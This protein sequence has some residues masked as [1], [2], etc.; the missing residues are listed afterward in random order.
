MSKYNYKEHVKEDLKRWLK[1]NNI[2]Q[3][4]TDEKWT[5]DEFRDWI[6]DEVWDDDDVTGNGTFFY[7]TEEKCSEYLSGN[8]N[9]LYNAIEE[10]HPDDNVNII[11]EEYENKSIARFF[12]CVIR[13]YFLGE[14]IE[15]IIEELKDE[16]KGF[17]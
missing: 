15:E 2:I 1:D 17:N 13:C 9:I 14:C 16:G 6:T 7:D 12:D 5:E 3:Q 11:I 8:F 4:A 10:Y